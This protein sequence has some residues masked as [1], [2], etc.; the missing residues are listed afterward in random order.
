MAI[1]SLNMG[2]LNL[3]VCNLKNKLAREEKEKVILQVELDKEGNFQREYKAKNVQKI[4]TLIQKL[5]NENWELKTKTTLMKSQD[6]EPKELRK[7]AKVLET[8][9][10]KWVETLFHYKQQQEALGSQVEALTKEKKEKENVLTDS[11]LV[12]LESV[13]LFNSKEQEKG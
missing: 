13:F 9:K 8:A 10:K 4:K 1:V 11:K 3:E 6:E 7:M 5:Q 2:N 12:N